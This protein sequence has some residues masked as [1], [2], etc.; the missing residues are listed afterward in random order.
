MIVVSD[1][2]GTLTIGGTVRGFAKYQQKHHDS[3]RFRLSLYGELA[4]YYA[5]KIGLASE[6]DSRI[7]LLHWMVR[8]L[9]GADATELDQVVNWLID[10]ELWAQRR[11]DVIA[12]LQAHR[13]AGHRVIIVSGT[14]API[15]EAFARC[16]GIEA[17]GSPLEF[18]SA[19][20]MTGKLAGE[21]SVRSEKVERIRQLAG[22]EPILAAYGDTENDVPM[23]EMASE[24]VA[25]YPNKQLLAEAEKRG[26]RI[27]GRL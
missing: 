9:K 2:E 7:R 19:G 22:G 15:A 27:L 16:I 10:Q 11:E 14:F 25:V 20:R 6:Q 1:L 12:E 23:L 4:I 8:Q 13:K 3:L 17:I 24:P 5:S 26:W 21:V 18:D